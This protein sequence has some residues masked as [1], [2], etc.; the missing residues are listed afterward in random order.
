MYLLEINI[1][2]LLHIVALFLILI[3]YR[4]KGTKLL[5]FIVLIPGLNVANNILILSGAII[6]FP[7]S[8]FI[9]FCIA[10]IYPVVVYEYCRFY[11]NRPL[12]RFTVFHAFAY[13]I[14]ALV[15]YFYID[16]LMMD[17]LSRTTYVEGLK[18]GHYPDEMMMINGLFVIGQF[19]FFIKALIEINKHIKTAK[20]FFS[21]VEK[22]KLRYLK[23]F[24]LYVIALNLL[25]TVAYAILPAQICEYIVIPVILNLINIFFVVSAF[26]NAVIFTP[27]QYCTFQSNLSPMVSYAEKS[28]PLCRELEQ[29]AGKGKY[30]LLDAE[31]EHYYKQLKA[32]LEE[33][34]IYLNQ[35]L[36]LAL[37]SESIEACSHH[38]SATIN[39]KFGMNFFDLINSYRIKSIV[40]YFNN[41]QINQQKI[42]DVAYTFGFNS[43]TAFYRAF[44]KHTGKSPGEYLSK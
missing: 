14:S 28:E 36:T 8:L 16:F 9:S 19:A 29:N 15:L 26:R 42:E 25:L 13:S 23:K 2:T 1:L 24:I 44:K 34:K 41:N 4:N 10:Q 18:S 39:S 12:F 5:A 35:N 43:K 7:E 38:V 33:E 27:E 6:H 31:I 20:A 40:D 30:K 32:K 22:L 17:D 37:L 11:M 21:D 3:F